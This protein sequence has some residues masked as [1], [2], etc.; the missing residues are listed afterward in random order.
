MRRREAIFGAVA[1]VLIV[2]YVVLGARVAPLLATAGTPS[3][4]PTKPASAVPAPRVPGTI[5]FALRGDIYVLSEGRYLG[6]TNDGRSASP[7]LTP[8]GR[9]VLFSRTET[10]DGKRVVDGQVTPAVLHYSDIVQRGVGG[11]AEAVMLTGLVQKATS[12]F[13]RVTWLT[14]PA[15]SPDGTKVAILAAPDDGSDASDLAVYDVRSTPSAPKRVAQLSLQSNLADVAWAPD[16]NSIAVTSYTLGAPRILLVPTDGRA[17]VPQK[18]DADGEAYRASFSP[19]G[20]WLVYTLRHGGGG[21]D[22]H[23]VEVATG[24]DVALSS[25]GKSWNGVFSPD[26]AWVAFLRETNSVVDLYAMEL[27]TAL[28]GGSPKTPL[29]LTRGEGIDGES[30]PAWG[31]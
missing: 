21:N 11:G 14:D 29:K 27:G 30:R 3:P 5:A 31:K 16:G 10:I 9:T 18:I 26:G 19:D 2:V 13:H 15:V 20:K 17:A 4:S 24:R 23:A 25:D 7:A 1:L 12:G 6:V 28:S 22:V 8:D